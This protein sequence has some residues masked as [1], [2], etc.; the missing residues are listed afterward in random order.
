M[1]IS[2]AWEWHGRAKGEEEHGT[3]QGEGCEKGVA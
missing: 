3:R 2:V 1:A